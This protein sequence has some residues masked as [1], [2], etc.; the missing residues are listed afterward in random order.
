[1]IFGIS[2]ELIGVEYFVS[3]KH[4]DRIEALLQE[5]AGDF[6]LEAALRALLPTG[7]IRVHSSKK[8]DGSFN[9]HAIMH[10]V[11]VD[12]DNELNSLKAVSL[13]NF[14][15]RMNDSRRE[16]LLSKAECSRTVRR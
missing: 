1:M 3:S 16:H 5:V 4:R 15:S 12:Y 2:R 13:L 11:D 6:F 8:K 10:G 14:M 7:A 9:R